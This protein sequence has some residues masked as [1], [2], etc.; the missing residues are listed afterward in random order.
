VSRIDSVAIPDGDHLVKVWLQDEAGN[1]EPANAAMLTVD[2]SKVTARAVDTKPPVLKDGPAPSSRLKITRARRSGSTL[3]ISGT[4]ARAASA[5]I[6]AQVSRSR[7]GKPVAAKARVKPKR[8]KWTAR[9][10]LPASLRNSRTMYLAVKYGGQNGYRAT[11][12]RRRLSE[13]APRAGRATDE[14]S[15]EARSGRR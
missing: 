5:R 2:P 13:K 7:T 11:T 8:G 4:I 3:T 10:R 6:E 14:F 1:A 15:V 9:V 12:L